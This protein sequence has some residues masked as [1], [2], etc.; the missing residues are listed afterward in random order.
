MHRVS[1]VDVMDNWATQF[2]EKKLYIILIR[3]EM[4]FIVSI[5]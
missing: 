3:H 5:K 4:H 1:S 2:G